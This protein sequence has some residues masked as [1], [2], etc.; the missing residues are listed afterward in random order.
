MIIGHYRKC[1]WKTS[2][3]LGILS[4]LA[5]RSYGVEIVSA[6][7]EYIE[8]E[9]FQRISEYF[10][11]EENPGRRLIVR[12]QAEERSGE[13]L[14]ITLD[15]NVQDLPS[16]A[17]VVIDLIISGTDKP[18]SHTLGLPAD[19][20]GTREIF[21]GITGS[22]WPGGD[23]TILA[24]KISIQSASGSTLAGKTSYLWKMP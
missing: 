6:H 18:V 5:I 24:W 17:Q 19:R 12:S 16:D 9:R 8:A 11:G 3:T 21:A 4:L 7:N 10:T 14:I 1:L 23:A 20:P 15:Q 22:D 13:Y 2:V